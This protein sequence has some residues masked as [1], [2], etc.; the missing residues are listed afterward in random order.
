MI[1]SRVPER[2]RGYLIAGLTVALAVVARFGL[3]PF[4]GTYSP[5][6]IFTLPVVVTALY[7]GFGPALLATALGASVGAFFFVGGIGWSRMTLGN[8]TGLMVFILIGLSVSFLGG[9]LQASRQ[10]LVDAS[11]RKDDFLASARRPNCSGA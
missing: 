10:S 5:L 6:L 2:A 7:G 3:N 8:A 11:R 4:L 9:R 1:F